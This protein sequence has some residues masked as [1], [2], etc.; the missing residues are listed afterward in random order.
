MNLFTAGRL[1]AERTPWRTARQTQTTSQRTY[2]DGGYLV[3]NEIIVERLFEKLI[4]GDRTATRAIVQETIDAGVSPEELSQAMYWPALEMINSLYRADQLSTLA[5][6]SGTRLLR[7]LVDQ[8]QARY[9]QRPSRDRTILM[10]SGPG[11]ADELAGQL[12]ADLAE[13]NGY[14]VFFGGGGWQTMRFLPRLAREA[15]IF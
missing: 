10:F 8:A 2:T 13:A 14:E 15:P 7:S 4:T 3:N 5:H 1:R 12:V 9:T 6:H 11:E